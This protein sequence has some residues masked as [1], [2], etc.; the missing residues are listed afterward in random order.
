MIPPHAQK[1]AANAHDSQGHWKNI[2]FGACS[3]KA[4][5]GPCS[6][7]GYWCRCGRCCRSKNHVLSSEREAVWRMHNACNKSAAEVK[8]RA[9]FKSEFILWEWHMSPYM[10]VQ[11]EMSVPLWIMWGD[12]S[13]TRYLYTSMHTSRSADG[14]VHVARHPTIYCFKESCLCASLAGACHP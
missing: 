5:I 11:Y 3:K 2:V 8:T 10:A 13:R 14:R 7:Q 1:S 12:C 9:N 4:A 6:S